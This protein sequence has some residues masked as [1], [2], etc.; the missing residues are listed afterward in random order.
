M[1]KTLIKDDGIE[2]L[3]HPPYRTD[4]AR[5]DFFLLLTVQKIKGMFFLSAEQAVV[6][7]ELAISGQYD[8]D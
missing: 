7:Y 6:A 4:W 2:N 8:L 3:P 5:C 1:K